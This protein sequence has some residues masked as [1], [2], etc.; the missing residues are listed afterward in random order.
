MILVVIGLLFAWP[1]VWVV[2][3]AFS[4]N[5]D[6]QVSWPSWTLI[7]FRAVSDGGYLRTLVNSAELGLLSM[8]VATVPAI[9]AGYALARRRIPARNG[10]MVGILFLTAV[11]IG[12]VVIPLYEF[13]SSYNVLG[14][15]PAGLFLGAT[16]LP[17]AIWLITGGIQAVPQ[18]LE[19]AAIA[20]SASLPQ[21]MLRIVLPLSAPSI[22]SA[23]FLSFIN[24]WGAFL[25]PLVLISD[26]GQQP[27]PLALFNFVHVGTT[28][29]GQIAA[30]S[31]LFSLPVV[32]VY[33]CATRF[34]SGGFALAGS[35]Q[36]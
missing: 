9:P 15:V 14:L 35:L 30:F 3:A 27:A 5:P 10:L 21:R 11:P 25:V 1:L 13:F 18:A 33:L 31:I 23:A 36:G 32:I 24:G 6:W 8:I 4:Q 7:N 19:E 26:P 22:A 17:F 12:I 28:Q 20:E 2:F 29:Y 16:N 34:I